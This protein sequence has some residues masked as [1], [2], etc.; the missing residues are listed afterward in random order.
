MLFARLVVFRGPPHQPRGQR[1]AVQRL[2]QGPGRHLLDQ[3]Q[4]R[5][6]VAIGHVQQRL[7][8]IP[9]QRQGAAQVLFRPLRH[10]LQIGRRQPVQHD[11]L[12]PAEQGGVEFE[13]RILSSG[14][15]QQDGA[16]FHMRQEPIL[17]RLVET[18]DLIHEQQRA[19]PVRAPDFRLFKDLAQFRHAGE[20]RTDLHEMQVRFRCQQPRDGGLAHARRPPEDQR[21]QAAC[22]QHRAQGAVR[23]QHL[24]LP[25][26]LGQRLWPQPVGQRARCVRGGGGQGIEQIGHDPTLSPWRADV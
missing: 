13:R 8:G 11:H 3:V 12:C 23:G 2:G 4:K 20:N 7:A 18:V 16:V 10:A 25:D 15:H 5:A 19:L 26:H 6:P 1:C 21:R 14:P 9:R 24:F 22:G 17:L